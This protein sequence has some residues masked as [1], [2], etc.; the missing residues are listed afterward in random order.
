MLFWPLLAALLLHHL[1]TLGAELML[2]CVWTLLQSFSVSVSGPRLQLHYS[3][4]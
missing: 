3:A 2:V 1:G 4:A